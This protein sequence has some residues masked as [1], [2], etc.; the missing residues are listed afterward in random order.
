M[1]A[2]RKAAARFFVIVGALGLLMVYSAGA[3]A[4]RP[5]GAF[6]DD[7]G[8][9]SY[10]LGINVLL[11]TAAWFGLRARRRAAASASTV[12]RPGARRC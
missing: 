2:S 11:V 3:L 1:P 12:A 4:T 10:E 6:L 7:A 8:Y 9:F 5:G